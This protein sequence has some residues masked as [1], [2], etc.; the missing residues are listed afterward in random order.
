MRS[1]IPFVHAA[2]RHLRVSVSYGSRSIRGSNALQ[3][4]VAGNGRSRVLY[5][6]TSGRAGIRPHGLFVR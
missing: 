5:G 2:A 3:K 1:R 6:E 4:T